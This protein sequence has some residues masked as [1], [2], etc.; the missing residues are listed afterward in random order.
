MQTNCPALQRHEAN[1]VSLNRLTNS[2]FEEGSV[3]DKPPYGWLDNTNNS[4]F[5]DD[6]QKY[7]GDKSLKIPSTA[8][9]SKSVYQSLTVKKG[10]VLKISAACKTSIPDNAKIGL[11]IGVFPIQYSS[12]HSGS[13]EWEILSIITAPLGADANIDLSLFGAQAGADAWFDSVQLV[14]DSF[15]TDCPATEPFTYNVHLDVANQE[16]AQALPNG[17]K[18]FTLHTRQE[19]KDIRFAF[20]TGKVGAPTEPYNSLLSSAPY[21]ETGLNL[22]GKSIYLASPT[23]FV[24][25]E[26][27][28]W[29]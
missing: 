16:Y 12:A 7:E 28:A 15:P 11:N 9:G 22:I 18:R 14:I 1:D 8:G 25:V 26:I 5:V 10:Q 20:A 24:V 6:S 3:G 29:T 2:G 13:S 17:T 27:Q 4:A 21:T 23:T 19:K